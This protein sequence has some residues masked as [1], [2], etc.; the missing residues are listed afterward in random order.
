MNA[1][2]AFCDA[3]ACSGSSRPGATLSISGS[4]L[5]NAYAAHNAVAPAVGLRQQGHLVGDR[6]QPLEQRGG[7]ALEAEDR[8][9][10]PS[11]LQGRPPEHEPLVLIAGEEALALQHTQDPMGRRYRQPHRPGRLGR[12]PLRV[13]LVEQREQGER[14]LEQLW[15]GHAIAIRHRQGPSPDRIRRHST[16]RSQRFLSTVVQMWTP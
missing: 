4:E 9:R 10:S 6:R 11:E 14:P 13:V 7:H 8:E 16:S 15:S 5:S 12:R 3:P 2:S 1:R